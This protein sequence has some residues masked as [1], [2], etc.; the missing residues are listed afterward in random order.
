[1]LKTCK[2]LKKLSSN[3]LK[4]KKNNFKT[5]LS[6]ITRKIKISVWFFNKLIKNLLI[7]INLIN[8]KLKLILLN[9][10]LLRPLGLLNAKLKINQSFGKNKF[11]IL[12]IKFLNFN[13][14]N[15]KFWSIKLELTWLN[16]IFYN[17]NQAISQAQYGF[18][19]QVYNPKNNNTNHW[20]V[21][22]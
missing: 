14:K 2:S 11:L 13:P 8:Y 15:L 1:M 18:N 3:K 21:I 20:V 16:L 19:L 4:N 9:L 12:Q 17:P 5:I 6:L 22:H 10:I 7:L